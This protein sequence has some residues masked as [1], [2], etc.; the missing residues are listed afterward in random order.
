MIRSFAISLLLASPALAQSPQDA[1]ARVWETFQST[2]KDALFDQAGFI[3]GTPNPGPNGIA[4]V[5][6]SPDGQ[7]VEARRFANDQMVTL[8]VTGLPGLR[9]NH[10]NAHDQGFNASRINLAQSNDPTLWVRAFEEIVRP[11]APA[12]IFGGQMPL[13]FVAKG[14]AGET[15]GQNDNRTHHY[16][17]LFNWN[18]EQIPVS[19]IVAPYSLVFTAQRIEVAE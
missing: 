10:C 5:A 1:M 8:R 2:C 9:I 4:T 13:G 3:T 16:A 14:M 6:T 7:L 12:P 15:I 17:A 19:I 11:T 18:G